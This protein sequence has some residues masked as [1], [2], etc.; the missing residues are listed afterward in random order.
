D[1]RAVGPTV[2]N[3]WKATLLRDLYNRT[4]DYMRG[5]QAGG[6]D[7]RVQVAKKDL[8]ERLADWPEK[9][10]ENMLALGSTAFWLSNH[11]DTHERLAHFMRAAEEVGEKIAVDFTIDSYRD[12]THMVIY[13]PDHPGLFAK[14]TGAL[15]LA[16][17]S[18][19]DA[20]ILTLS[21]GMALDTFS[22][23]DF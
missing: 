9:M 22:L 15:A 4:D 1:I 10:R 18:V 16:G 11:T 17:V 14:I 23:Q 21:N 6:I 3:N 20:N 13:T 5:G 8:A 2:W 12:V 19:V 7:A